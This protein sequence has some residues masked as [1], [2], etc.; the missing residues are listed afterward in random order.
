MIDAGLE[1]EEDRLEAANRL[2]L[3]NPDQ[4]SKGDIDFLEG[5]PKKDQSGLVDKLHFGSGYAYPRCR[6]PPA[7][8]AK[9]RGHQSLSRHRW[10]KHQLKVDR[11]VLKK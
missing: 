1:L 3:S 5:T 9:R 4:W 10:V 11:E 2:K 8:A 7:A 6:C